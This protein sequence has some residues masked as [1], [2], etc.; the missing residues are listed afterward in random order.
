MQRVS[1]RARQT[2]LS[3]GGSR[4]P[5]KCARLPCKSGKKNQISLVILQ[6][7]QF[8]FHP[9]GTDDETAQLRSRERF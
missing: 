8:A 2:S 4:A 9:P 3:S 5:R 1:G 6:R 7:D